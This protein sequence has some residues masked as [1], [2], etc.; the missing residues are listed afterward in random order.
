MEAKAHRY[1][2]SLIGTPGERW[3]AATGAEQPGPP[4]YGIALLSRFPAHGW[5]TT[6]MPAIPVRV[7]MRLPVSRRVVIVREEPRLLLRACVVAPSG[8]LTIATTHLSFVPGWNRLQ[9]RRIARDV[10]DLRDPVVLMGD[11]NMSA[12]QASA[13]TGFRRLATA[14]T[15]PTDRPQRQLDHIL[16]RGASPR[17]MRV[18]AAQLPVSDHRALVV[19]LDFD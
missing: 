18:R 10:A 16:L 12:R 13:I 17:V 4:T 5:R 8:P 2:A 19:D 9:L 1:V 14:A 3:T 11:L 7:P 6:R 15:F